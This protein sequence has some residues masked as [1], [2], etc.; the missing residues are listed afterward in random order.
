MLVAL[1]SACSSS[2]T[3]PKPQ[4]L[5]QDEGQIG[6]REAW[7]H[8]IAAV[9]FPL[10]LKADGDT[11]VLAT[12]E[13]QVLALNV[14][15]GQELWRS[16][17][18]EGV[19]A[20]VGYDGQTTAVITRDN[21]LVALEAGRELWRQ[22]LGAQS[23]TPPLV[24]GA[25]VFVLGGDRSVLAFD[26]Q[27]GRRLWTYQRTADT[28]LLRQAGVLLPVGNT[29]VVGFGGKLA[30]LDPSTGGLRW[31]APIASPRGT[32]EV[33][34]LVDLVVPL[35]RDRDVVCARAF[36]AAV[37]CVD[38]QRGTLLWS[39]SANGAEGLTGDVRAVY[40]VEGDGRLQAWSR[41][42]GAK[43]WEQAALRYR[44]LVQPVLVGD[45]LVVGE[46]N[47]TLHFLSRETGALQGRIRPDSTALA[48]TPLLVGNTLVLV[49]RR[50]RVLGLR[51]E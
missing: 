11:V 43:L 30:G 44:T 13:G 6:W 12:G 48:A 36:L 9:N 4:S 21:D 26:A 7:S 25:R 14:S 28:L 37:G 22:R 18:A 15:T 41:L 39:Q 42:S 32:N 27:S 20:A 29:L 35:S 3:R 10:A 46:D 34:R 31:E 16:V 17:V 38:V 23:L 19:T 51:P 50:G 5:P 2:P 33:E 47:G 45:S 8:R 1:L 40:G 24:A 49:T